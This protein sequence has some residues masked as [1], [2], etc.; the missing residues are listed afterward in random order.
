MMADIIRKGMRNDDSIAFFFATVD[1]LDLMCL[2]LQE[3]I[4]VMANL[5]KLQDKRQLSDLVG[6]CCT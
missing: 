2:L 3:D 5:V 1:N 4:E 6:G